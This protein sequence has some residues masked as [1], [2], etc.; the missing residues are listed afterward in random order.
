[1]SIEGQLADWVASLGKPGAAPA[2]PVDE[3][4][5][6]ERAAG[7]AGWQLWGKAR[8]EPSGLATAHPLLLHMTDVAAVTAR[9]LTRVLPAGV[10]RR[11]LATVSEDPRAALSVLLTVAALHDF[12]K[13]SP[14]FQK[15]SVSMASALGRAGFDFRPDRN[16][17]HHGDFGMVLLQPRLVD[18]GCPTGSA[19]HLARAVTGH[20]GELP[21]DS[22]RRASGRSERGASPRWQSARDEIVDEITALFEPEWADVR[23]KLDPAAALSVAG[24]VSLSDWLGSLQE[25]FVY[26]PPCESLASYWPRSLERADRALARAGFRAPIDTPARSFAE[27]FEGYTPWPLHVTVAEVASRLAA[28]SLVV[29]EAPMGEGKTEAAFLL[30]EAARERLGGAGLYVGLPTRATANQMFGRTRRFLERTRGEHPTTLLLAHGEASLVEEARELHPR[31]VYDD[32]HADGS[33]VRAEAWFQSKKRTLLAEF[34][35]GTIDQAL[36]GVM[37]VPHQFVRLFGLAG[38]TVVLDEVH[39]YDTYTGRILDRLVEWLAAVGTTVVLLSATLPRGRRAEIVA[40]YARGAGLPA[41]GA[42]DAPYPRVTVVG[43]DGVVSRTFDARGAPIDVALE[44]AAPDLPELARRACE[45]ARTGACVGWICNSVARAQE[46]FRL[47][48]GVDDRLLI[49]SRLLPDDRLRRERTLESWLGPAGPGR[50]RPTGCVVVGTQVLEQSLDV[51]FDLMITDVAPVDLVLQRAGRLHRHLRSNRAIAHRAARLVL[52]RPEGDPVT[53]DLADVAFVY[54]ELVTRRSLLALAARTRIVLP[55]DIEPLVAQVYDAPPP[56][57]DDPLYPAWEQSVGRALCHGQ[58]AEQRLLPRVDAPDDPFTDLQV[59]LKD[60]D[61]PELHAA[62][63]AATRLAEPSVEVVCLV[64]RG[65]QILVGDGDTTPV[66]LEEPPQQDLVVRLVRRSIGVGH[67]AVVHALLAD[68]AASPTG[69]QSSAV[70]R[71]RRVLAFED[72]EAE[73]AGVSLRLDPEL[74]LVIGKRRQVT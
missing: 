64:R 38:K 11:L 3:A 14:A 19:T 55:D 31:A 59:F 2:C 48:D 49:H 29:V 26:E 40:A 37:R 61:D 46:A 60:E 52:V 66:D 5:W 41:S 39:A 56:A 63:R 8:P 43:S 6:F 36:L 27:L 15:K 67:R 33:G 69:W 57:L 1:M 54:D 71:Y 74:G 16:A 24:L 68:P 7:R 22:R 17:R 51:D 35:V 32:D 42:P 47:L 30:A 73:V 45:A 9:L 44:P 12:G 20:H 50:E 10:R 23:A 4:E 65:Q 58:N 34:A 25:V 70:L 13:A 72:G 53:V 18:L 21:P 28:P 62:L